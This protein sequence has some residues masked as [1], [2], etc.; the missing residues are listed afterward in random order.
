MARKKKELPYQWAADTKRIVPLGLNRETG[1]FSHCYLFDHTGKTRHVK[2]GSDEFHE[3]LNAMIEAMGDSVRE[4]AM[5]VGV[6]Q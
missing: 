2:V 1:E 6:L 3:H 5:T 4:E